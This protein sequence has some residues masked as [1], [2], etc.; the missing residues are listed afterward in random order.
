M[1]MTGTH[2]MG[3]NLKQDINPEVLKKANEISQKNQILYVDNLMEKDKD[4]KPYDDK[5]L[6]PCNAY[7]IVKPYT[8]NPYRVPLRKSSSGL[9]LGDFETDANYKSQETG[10]KEASEVG[11]C[12]AEVIAVGPMCKNV[13]VGEDVILNFRIAAPV[14]FGNKGYY[15]TSEQNIICSIRKKE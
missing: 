4:C 14:P 3:A 7:V 2:Y 9:I 10:E 15:A 5:I 12:C 13:I 6:C 1:Q 11:I 8:R